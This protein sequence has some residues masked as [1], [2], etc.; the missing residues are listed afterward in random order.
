MALAHCA[1]QY[2]HGGVV[3]SR[4][5]FHSL[6]GSKQKVYQRQEDGYE[7]EPADGFLEDRIFGK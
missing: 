4:S 2:E 6:A 7:H 1:S 5:V 3:A